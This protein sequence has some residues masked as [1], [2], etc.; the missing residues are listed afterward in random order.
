MLCYI[1]VCSTLDCILQ[2]YLF[3]RI[4]TEVPETI[5]GNAWKWQLG[6]LSIRD[7]PKEVHLVYWE[8]MSFSLRHNPL[9]TTST[10]MI[11]S[12]PATCILSYRFHRSY[13]P[14]QTMTSDSLQTSALSA[15]RDSSGMFLEKSEKL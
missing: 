6:T 3:L 1:L 11:E 8:R 7:P 2:V 15:D 10:M 4:R 5:L 14:E 9:V 12:L 13:L